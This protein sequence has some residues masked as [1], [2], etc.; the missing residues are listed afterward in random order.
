MPFL[1]YPPP[2][3]HL[4]LLLVLAYPLRGE[5]G[6]YH[7]I[8][9]TQVIDNCF[10]QPL[11]IK[12]S[13]PSRLKNGDKI[14]EE[15][16]FAFGTD[17]DSLLEIEF[18]SKSSKGKFRLGR[19]SGLELRPD[20]SLNLHRGSTLCTHKDF[21]E[22]KIA[23]SGCSVH[24]QGAGTWMLE[25]LTA[26]LK[27]ILLEGEM[28]IN[29]SN[30]SQIMKSGD[31][32][33]INTKSSQASKPIQ[34]ELPLLLGTSR[35]INGFSTPLPSKTRMISA[36]HVQALRLKRRYEAFVGDV[37]EEKKLQLWKLPQSP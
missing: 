4:G 17:K 34:V 19:K 32:V 26:G 5:I 1:Y 35:L 25:C 13:A 11:A 30:K 21:R 31:L 27:F 36:A 6:P 22:W 8:S 14:L 33:I 37:S 29:N 9:V 18:L 24:I 3:L 16:P 2:Y 10:L 15:R 28:S 23:S 12:S 7:S 20:Y